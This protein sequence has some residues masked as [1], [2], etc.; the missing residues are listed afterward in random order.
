MQTAAQVRLEPENRGLEGEAT[1]EGCVESG[2][3]CEI[4]RGA[5]ESQDLGGGSHLAT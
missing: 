4:I 1:Q 5:A 3:A 2:P